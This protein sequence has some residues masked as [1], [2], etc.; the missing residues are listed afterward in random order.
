MYAELLDTPDDARLVSVASA[1]HLR[2]CLDMAIAFVHKAP[3]KVGRFDIAATQWTQETTSLMAALGE[4]MAGLKADLRL[5][6]ALRGDDPDSTI[7]GG[8]KLGDF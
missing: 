4:I 7:L 1:P 8:I 5:R 3:A 6:A 2:G